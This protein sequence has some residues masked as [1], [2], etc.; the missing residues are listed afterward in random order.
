MPPPEH[1]ILPPDVNHSQ[2]DF[3]IETLE[4]GR[5]AIRFGLAA[6]KNAGARALQDLVAI[7]GELPFASLI[8]FCQRVDMRGLGKRTLESLIKVGALKPFGTRSGLLAALDRIAQ[9]SINYHR[10]Q[11]VGQ[12]DLFGEASEM[13]I[14]LLNGGS[15]QA[16][17]RPRELLKWEKELLGVYVTGRPVDRHRHLLERQNLHKVSDLKLAGSDKPEV[18]RIAG[19]VTALRRITTRNSDLMAILTVED[20][21]ESA[22][23]IEVVLFPRTY[24]N[25]IRAFE[26]RTSST[27][28]DA[29]APS[30]SEG[31]IVAIVGRY[32][33]G[34]GDPQIIADSL[35]TDFKQL[36]I[37]DDEPEYQDES[38]P[39]WAH[40]DEDVVEA[41]AETHHAPPNTEAP[42]EIESTLPATPAPAVSPTAPRCG[43]SSRR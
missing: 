7:R 38:E 31:E 9:Y 27:D 29:P 36:Q 18:V 19:E 6:V 25:V 34:R 4:D 26:A 33:E 16:E 41:P 37:D 23:S 21:H 40:V 3:D 13:D 20:W 10:D 22:E 28:E 43:N 14:D 8:D 42:D 5:R 39:V 35:T 1:P 2:L 32:D 12:L 30:L 24:E 15:K 11:E 17:V